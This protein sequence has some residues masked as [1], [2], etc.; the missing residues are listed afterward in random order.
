[1]DANASEVEGGLSGP[2]GSVGLVGC[3]GLGFG[4]WGFRVG[5]S[6]WDFRGLGF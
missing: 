3:R 4:I 6:I 2:K 5:F 1:M